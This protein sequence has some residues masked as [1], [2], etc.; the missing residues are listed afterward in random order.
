MS[1]G[2]KSIKLVLEVDQASLSKTRSLVRE[3]TSDLTKLA[4]AAS[5]SASGGGILGGMNLS[6]GAKNTPDGNRMVAKTPAI[7]KGLVQGFLDQKNIFK[8]I[9]DGSKESMRVMTDSLKQAISQQKAE[10]KSLDSVASDLAKRY[11]SI[12]RLMKGMGGQ[13][14]HGMIPTFQ[15][16]QNQVGAQHLGAIGAR[17]Q[18]AAN[19]QAL[20]A[21]AQAAGLLP[22]PL[23][24][25][26]RVMQ[27]TPGMMVGG[28][29]AGGGGPG[30]PTQPPG[31]SFGQRMRGY[32]ANAGAVL[33]GVSVLGGEYQAVLGS[34]QSFQAQRNQVFAPS[35]S[36]M[37][38]GDLSYGLAAI[39]AANRS[40]E[41]GQSA[42]EGSTGTVAGVT[43]AADG[44]L[45]G[46]RNA[47]SKA[48][49]G[50][51]GGGVTFGGA[52]PK[53]YNNG[54]M[55][56]GLA[57]VELDREAIAVRDRMALS[58]FSSSM[59]ERVAYQQLLGGGGFRK[60]P[61]TGE[62][63]DTYKDRSIALGS[64]GY[65]MGAKMSAYSQLMSGG[66][67]R[68][69]GQNADL[70]MRAASSGLGGFSEILT[71]GGRAGG[72]NNFALGAIGGGIDRSA[73]V[74]LGSAII[75]SGFD[76]AGTTSGMG[77]LAA[78]QAG[79]GFSGGI[80]DF[81]LAQR[82]GAGMRTTDSIVGGGM[83]G[84]QKGRNLVGAIDI[85]GGGASTYAQDFLANGLTS[86][87]MFDIARD[88]GMVDTGRKDKNGKPIREMSD[89]A[90]RA[91]GLLG[92]DYQSKISQMY[93]NSMT[94][95]LDRFVD[96]GGDDRLSRTVREF[97]ESGGTD[98]MK[99]AKG[100][101]RADQVQLAGFY[102]DQTETGLEGGMGAFGLGKG[103]GS[104]KVRQGSVG[105]GVEGAEKTFLEA[106]A[107]I[108]TEV[109]TALKNLGDNVGNAASINA[110]NFIDYA[111][112]STDFGKGVGDLVSALQENTD[113]LTGRKRDKNGK[114]VAYDPKT[115]GPAT[116]S[117]AKAFAEAK[118]R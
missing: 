62:Y 9:A 75:G 82:V 77:L 36:G 6:G 56:G 39:R 4:E 15:A 50:K 41:F 109:S 115:M 54:R 101:S 33:G 45:G 28:G 3:L 46:V 20:Q 88:G 42:L 48:V 96:Q 67:S 113:A 114:P 18:A 66:G 104:K 87:Q 107:K 63:L 102:G 103:F 69:A 2:G 57:A 65:S 90:L 70:A 14:D 64:R 89:I 27:V 78:A 34:A 49:S 47:V 106:Q 72:G 26:G 71:A 81:N 38:G 13:F 79:M 52:T 117:A 51:G 86:K 30:V 112:L 22:P 40:G 91:Q 17:G 23:P 68:F 111:K 21:Q 53:G 11:E 7:G 92:N 83:D 60:D 8:G 31:P 10:L 25:G 110:K 100:L 84:Y 12:G 58:D 98:V 55:A 93:G 76:A 61:K 94:S 105:G 19:L 116:A 99:F 32:A 97:R 85:L 108:Q 59:G 80:R 5:K 24:P 29:G 73:G 74:Q 1:N 35:M 37:A 95:V 44:V 16:T 118:K 43:A